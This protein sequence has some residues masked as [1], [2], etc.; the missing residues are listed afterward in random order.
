MIGKQQTP[1]CIQ[2]HQARLAGASKDAVTGKIAQ[3]C[4][5]IRREINATYSRETGQCHYPRNRGIV[6]TAEM[7]RRASVDKN[8]LKRPYHAH[9]QVRV[10]RIVAWAAAKTQR[11]TVE[12]ATNGARLSQLKSAIRCRDEFAQRC[13][14]IEYCLLETERK[15][16]ESVRRENDQLDRIREL[17]SKLTRYLQILVRLDPDHIPFGGRGVS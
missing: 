15:L 1:D 6:G 9:S 3:A 13:V 16:G 17:E 12:K 11:V 7:L 8:T 14:A 4:A 5:D 10:R 2:S